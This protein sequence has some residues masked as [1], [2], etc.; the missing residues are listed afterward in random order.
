MTYT[1]AILEVDQASYDDIAA[2]IK[3]INE[4]VGGNQYGHMFMD[5]GGIDLTGIAIKPEKKNDG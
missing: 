2:R 5:D 1:V 3:A 4:R